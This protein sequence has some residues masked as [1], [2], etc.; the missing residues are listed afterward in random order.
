[1]GEE[2]A[3]DVIIFESKGAGPIRN[4]LVHAIVATYNDID[5]PPV[6]GEVQYVVAIGITDNLVG[7]VVGVFGM[8]Q[9]IALPPT[10]SLGVSSPMNR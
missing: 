10:I 2:M 4:P 8:N 5:A 7:P 9:L 6:Q 1:M 3:I